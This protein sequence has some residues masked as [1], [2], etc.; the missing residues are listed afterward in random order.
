MMSTM[1]IGYRPASHGASNAGNLMEANFKK[2]YNFNI[3]YNY[4]RWQ[5]VICE[6][7]DTVRADNL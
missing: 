6:G 7:V 4:N 2:T 1:E 3:T 5:S